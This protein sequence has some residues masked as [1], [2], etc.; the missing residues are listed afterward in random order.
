MTKSMTGIILAGGESSR[1]GEEKFFIP[2]SGK[3]LIEYTIDKLSGIFKSLIIVTKEPHLYQKYGIRAYVDIMK[4]RGPLGGIH[5]GL[6]YSDTAYNFVCACD[7]PFLNTGLIGFM[8]LMIE[9]YDVVIP[10]KNGRF[11]PLCAVYSKACVEPIKNSLLIGNLKM[12]DFLKDV[13]VRTVGD[14]EIA[15]FD[16]IGHSFAN[17]NTPENL[18]RYEYERTEA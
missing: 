18:R 5:A 13:K 7:M 4:G 2:F 3:P 10:K 17:I 11:E 8:A 9:G 16:R 1:M 15:A 6:F 12:T 14:E